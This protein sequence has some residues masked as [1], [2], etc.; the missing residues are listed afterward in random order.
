MEDN[1]KD[2]YDLGF[3]V[4][5]IDERAYGKSEGTYTSLGWKERIDIKDWAW[6]IAK[7]FPN[8]QI[9]TWGI[10]MGSATVMLSCGEDMPSNFKLCIAD[11][12]YN[13]FY[14]L[15]YYL[16]GHTMGLPSFLTTFILSS[17]S[18]IAK[19]RHKTNIKF[20]VQNALKDLPLYIPLLPDCKLYSLMIA[21]PLIG[22]SAYFI[23]KKETEK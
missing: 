17:T 2:F 8:S 6:Y 23:K 15:L 3:N 7:R 16:C 1:I 12:G 14:D 5:I 10:S 19:L 11:C 18:L 21:I 20:S 22:G 9:V 13:S 4:L